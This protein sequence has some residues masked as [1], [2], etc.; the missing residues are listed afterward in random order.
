MEQADVLSILDAIEER[1]MNEEA[2]GFSP[3]VLGVLDDMDASTN[4]IEMLKFRIGQDILMRIFNFA[5]S[6][7]FGSLKK[8]SIH[9]FYEVVTRLGMAHTKA[10]I[11][12]LSLQLMAHDDPEIEEIFARCFSSAV[13]GKILAGQFGMR[14][15]AAKKIEL[16]GLFSE[17]GRMIIEVY[18][19]FHA[20]DDGR[21]D[22]AFVDKYHPYLTE[23]V[24]EKF[25]LPDYLKTMIFHDGIVVEANYFTLSGIAQMAINMVANSFDRNHGRLVIESL[26]LPAGQDQEHALAKVIMDQFNAV[27]LGKYLSVINNRERILPAY[28][29][30]DE[31]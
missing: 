28:E 1:M 23:R 19:K 27:G 26:P 12:I 18:K 13:L 14:E 11:I 16:G 2:L 20:P 4:D 9:T 7:Y 25:A 3:A 29:P 21:I 8:G 10:M 24:I 5:S 6:A 17:T 15:E 30:A 22:K 31:S